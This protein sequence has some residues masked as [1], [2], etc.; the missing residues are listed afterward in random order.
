[1]FQQTTE[2]TPGADDV[3][4]LKKMKTLLRR[5]GGKKHRCT[6]QKIV[7]IKELNGLVDVHDLN[8]GRSTYMD[9]ALKP[10]KVLVEF[11]QTQT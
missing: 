4:T 10:F 6:P 8:M 2:A 11:L 5:K 9:G 1:M 3:M 7:Y